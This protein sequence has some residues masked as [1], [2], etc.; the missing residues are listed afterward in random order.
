MK[1]SK[2][3][4]L[5]FPSSV[6]IRMIFSSSTL[7]AETISSSPMSFIALTPWVFLPIGLISS[8]LV[9][10]PFPLLVMNITSSWSL[11]ISVSTSSSPSSRM[12]A[13]TPFVFAFLKS[14]ITTRFVTPFFVAIKRYASSLISSLLKLMIEV[15]FSSF[16]IL[17]KFFIFVPFVVL[18]LSGISY[19]LI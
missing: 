5:P 8:T 10:R 12:I 1:L 7:T 19:A 11:T 2:E 15:I 3:V 9:L 16:S 18:P 6:R 4:R 14:V 17:R 13:L